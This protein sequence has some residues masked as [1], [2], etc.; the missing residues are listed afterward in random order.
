M[1]KKRVFIIGWEAKVWRDKKT[2][3][4][5]SYCPDLCL[6]SQGRTER[7]AKDAISSAVALF[8][9]NSGLYNYSRIWNTI[10]KYREEKA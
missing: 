8:L 2:K 3:I 9:K 4:F 1:K 5:V 10:G 7:E 6:Y